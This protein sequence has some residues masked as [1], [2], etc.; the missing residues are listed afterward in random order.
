MSNHAFVELV[1]A[2]EEG[3]GIEIPDLEV[4]AFGG[5]RDV[6]DWLEPHL[7]GKCI[8]QQTAL[9]P[10]NLATRAPFCDAITTTQDRVST[11]GVL[12]R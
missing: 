4:A 2:I 3:P 7:I 6:V 9:L 8:D 5:P 1:M 10:E 12:P 11:N